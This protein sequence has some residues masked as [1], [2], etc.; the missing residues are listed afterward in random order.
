MA[1][2]H[3]PHKSIRTCPSSDDVSA[4][5][6]HTQN[7]APAERSWDANCQYGVGQEFAVPDPAGAEERASKEQRP[8]GCE[9]E[10]GQ[11]KNATFPFGCPDLLPTG[12]DHIR[13]Q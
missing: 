10:G 5:E 1:S 12:S 9:G 6:H 11:D 3:W 8:G 4:G 7:E 2:R 13:L